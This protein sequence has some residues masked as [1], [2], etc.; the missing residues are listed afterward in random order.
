MIHQLDD[1]RKEE[2][3]EILFELLKL[4]AFELN[5]IA[6]YAFRIL[7]N[8]SKNLEKYAHQYIPKP[9]GSPIL[10]VLDY[11]QELEPILL[12]QKTETEISKDSNDTA[13]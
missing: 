6:L 11:L 2:L 8:S 5:I 9:L 12:W 13:E 4:P 10:T 7:G 3:R 1:N